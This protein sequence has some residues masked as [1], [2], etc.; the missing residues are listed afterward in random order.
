MGCKNDSS[1]LGNPQPLP[2]SKNDILSQAEKA[3]RTAMARK[4]FDTDNMTLIIDDVM[5]ETPLDNPKLKQVVAKVNSMTGWTSVKKS[6]EELL[7]LCKTNYV[8]ELEG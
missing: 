7:N 2:Y 8:R 1:V 3:I 6:I 5:G 4:N